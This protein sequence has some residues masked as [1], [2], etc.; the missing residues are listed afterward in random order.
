[1]R[2]R[3]QKTRS[4][5]IETKRQPASTQHDYDENRSAYLNSLAF[6]FL[7]FWKH[8]IFHQTKQSIGGNFA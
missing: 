7:R 8:E 2:F 3:L 5:I 6:T 1:I 4:I